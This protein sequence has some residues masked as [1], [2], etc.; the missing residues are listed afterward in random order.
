VCN[1]GSAFERCNHTKANG[2]KKRFTLNDM[3]QRTVTTQVHMQ[4]IVAVVRAYK[5]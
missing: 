1:G 4:A 3:T 2:K 5:K